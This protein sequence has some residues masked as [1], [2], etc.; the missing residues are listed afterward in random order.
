[1]HT[2]QCIFEMFKIIESPT[3]M[4]DC[5]NNNGFWIVWIMLA[6]DFHHHITKIY[7]DTAM[8]EEG[9]LQKWVRQFKGD[10]ENM[11]L[12]MHR[13]AAIET[14]IRTENSR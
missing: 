7:G 9:K 8:I 11:S 6:A 10:H 4:G 12:R 3:I 5:K 2:S 1:M 13:L 14:K